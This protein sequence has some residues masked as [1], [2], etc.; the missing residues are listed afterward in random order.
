MI[1]YAYE[2]KIIT[3]FFDSIMYII[4]TL[5]TLLYGLFMALLG[6]LMGQLSCM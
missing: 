4:V 5:H 2:N 1:L 6:V 3:K